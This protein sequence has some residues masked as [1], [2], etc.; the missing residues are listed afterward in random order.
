MHSNERFNQPFWVVMGQI[1]VM[2]IKLHDSYFEAARDAWESARRF[3]GR[4]FV[5]CASQA[6]V[7]INAS[8]FAEFFVEPE[9]HKVEFAPEPDSVDVPIKAATAR[10]RGRPRRRAK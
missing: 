6:S 3:P 1:V 5:V 2:P 8:D 4:R 10:K 7:S 9:R